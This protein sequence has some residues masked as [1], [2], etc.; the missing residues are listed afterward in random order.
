M[1]VEHFLEKNEVREITIFNQLVL[2]HGVL[3]YK[4]MLDHLAVS[5]ASLD[6][7][8]ES[9]AARMSDFDKQVYIQYDG[10]NIELIMGDH[11]SLQHIYRLYLDQSIKIKII[12]YLFKHQK[13]SIT[14]LTLKLAISESSL[15]RKIR[16]LNS[17]LKEFGIK[18]RNGQLHGEELQ[19]RYFYFHFYSYIED[20]TTLFTVH[21]DSQMIQTMQSLENFLKVTILPENRERLST[22]LFISKSRITIKNQ[23]HKYLRE[24]MKPYVKDPLYHKIQVMIL[25]YFSRYSIEV[26][27]GEAM[28]HFVFLLA[29]PI[30]TEDDFHEYTLIRD[31]HAPVAALDMYIAETIINHFKFRKLPY[32]L[33]REIYYH[34]THIHTQL[35]F[36]QGDIERFEYRYISAKEKQIFGDNLVTFSRE[37]IGTSIKR[38]RVEA[39]DDNSLIKM[40]VFKYINLLLL[41]SFKMAKVLQIGIDLKMDELYKETLSELLILKMSPI[42]GIHIERYEPNKEYDLILTNDKTSDLSGYEGARVYVLSEV[43]SSFD[44]ANIQ[45]IIQELNT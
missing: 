3:S 8:L 10:Q 41:L 44:L 35:Y 25:R 12:N 1:K 14:Q 2:N 6:N 24:K 7:D 23:K 33:E 34:L 19:I 26:D 40:G 18:I 39:G 20:K 36:F 15:F 32:M 4:D 22:W 16:D 27:E 30:L 28:L 43:L 17:H 37:I 29:F 42:Q 45:R 9:I 11:I 38:F 5:K 13:F 21:A 31:R